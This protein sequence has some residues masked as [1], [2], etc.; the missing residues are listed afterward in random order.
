M[1]PDFQRRHVRFFARPLFADGKARS[2]SQIESDPYRAG[3]LGWY[4]TADSP[5][6]RPRP[7]AVFRRRRGDAFKVD[8]L[9]P[10]LSARLVAISTGALRI[11]G[12][13]QRGDGFQRQAW[14]VVFG[15]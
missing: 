11:D 9:P 8:V 14:H 15:E 12:W 6:S 13:E 5:G 7:I 10:L 1:Q 4:F 3:E 2:A